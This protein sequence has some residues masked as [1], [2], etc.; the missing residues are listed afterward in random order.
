MSDLRDTVAWRYQWACS[1]DVRRDW[2]DIWTEI[3]ISTWVTSHLRL[4]NSTILTNRAEEA[5]RSGA[6][7]RKLS[8]K[9][10][11]LLFL[12]YQFARVPLDPRQFLRYIYLIHPSQLIDFHLCV[13]LLTFNR[14]FLRA[15]ERF[16]FARFRRAGGWDALSLREYVLSIRL[17]YR[18]RRLPTGADSPVIVSPGQR[19][20]SHIDRRGRIASESGEARGIRAFRNC[21][22]TRAYLRR[23]ADESP[24]RD[25]RETLNR[26]VNEWRSHR[27]S[28]VIET[29]PPRSLLFTVNYR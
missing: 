11:S 13:F 18:Y 17:L 10:T 15:G 5:R 7:R 27:P 14:C 19:R 20:R 23:R 1:L 2:M 16:S 9:P 4:W 8:I 12:F 21:D 29:Q 3:S 28:P 6:T 22:L 25:V 24:R 26:K